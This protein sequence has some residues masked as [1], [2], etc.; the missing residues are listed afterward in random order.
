MAA[1]AFEMA[2]APQ[3][4]SRSTVSILVTVALFSLLESVI[5]G[6]PINRCSAFVQIQTKIHHILRVTWDSC[7]PSPIGYWMLKTFALPVL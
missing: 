3:P 5:P 4:Y 2:D 1:S 6:S 7:R